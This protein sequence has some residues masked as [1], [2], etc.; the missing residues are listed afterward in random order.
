[1]PNRVLNTS[2]DGTTAIRNET[3]ALVSHGQYLYR[4]LKGGIVYQASVGP[5]G[6][7]AQ[8]FYASGLAT[9]T[10]IGF[11]EGLALMMVYDDLSALSLAA[12][13]A[14]R[15]LPICEDMP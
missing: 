13:I 7:T 5:K 8:R 3:F 11:S 2:P 10:G 15:K 1:V 6:V 9:P 4:A 14:V 12:Q